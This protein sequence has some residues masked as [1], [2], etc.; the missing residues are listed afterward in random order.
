LTTLKLEDNPLTQ[1]QKDELREA[2]PNCDIF[3]G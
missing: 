2:L 3:F 1:T